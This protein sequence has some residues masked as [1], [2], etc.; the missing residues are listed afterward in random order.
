MMII[1][2]FSHPITAPQK[3]QIETLTGQQVSRTI[4]IPSQFDQAESFPDQ[5]RILVD[6]IDLTPEDWQTLPIL[7]NPPSYNFAAM[8]LL[9]ELHGRMGYFPGILRIRP[10]PEITPP[11]YEVAEIINLQSV[12]ENA[13]RTR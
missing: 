13:R 10:V 9:A 7:I 5:I 3:A 11:R 12:R 6:S 8:T 2:N 4:D 1:L